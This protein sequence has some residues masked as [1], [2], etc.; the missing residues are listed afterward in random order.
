MYRNLLC[1][2]RKPLA[3]GTRRVAARALVPSFALLSL[4]ALAMLLA[5]VIAAPSRARAAT[6]DTY[7]EAAWEGTLTS[8]LQGPVDAG[9]LVS[10][11][12]VNGSFAESTADATGLLAVL[13]D[14]ATANGQRGNRLLAQANWSETLTNDG[15]ETQSYAA[16]VSIPTIQLFFSGSGFHGVALDQRNAAYRITLLVNDEPVFSSEALLRSGTSGHVLE[17]TGTDLGGVKAP[18]NL[19]YTFAPSTHE[20]F[21]GV[22]APTETLNMVLT[23]ES[24]IDIPGFEILADASIGDPI[25]ETRVQITPFPLPEPGSDAMLIAG[26]ASLG[27]RVRH[28]GRSAEALR[29][30]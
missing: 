8:D 20:V 5:P 15:G 13:V 16:T 25:G 18:T 11:A 28:R 27:L 3:V 9:A 30:P 10:V 2:Q 4:L 21:L 24:S 14:G 1:A 26:L 6:I 23:V 12:D 7:A 17:E 19:R 22:A 29:R